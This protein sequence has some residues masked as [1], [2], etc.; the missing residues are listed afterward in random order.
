MKNCSAMPKSIL[1]A[2]KMGKHQS[3]SCH[4]QVATAE[5]AQIIQNI[6]SYL[7]GQITIANMR[8]LTCQQLWEE[9]VTELKAQGGFPCVL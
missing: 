6:L 4:S 3:C 1:Q 9:I 8:G 7:A 2:V 5:E